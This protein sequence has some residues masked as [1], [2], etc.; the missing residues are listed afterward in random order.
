MSVL[1]EQYRS[2]ASASLDSAVSLPFA[3]YHDKEIYQ[4]ESE[5]IFR[6]EWV[7]VCAE[8][9]LPDS[10]D[11]L[12]MEL[13]GESI[14]I[15]RGKDGRLR[16]LS[17]NCRHRGTPL[18]EPG[19]GNVA[20]TIVCPYHAWSYD[21]QGALMGIPFPGAVTIKKGDHCLPEFHL[22]IYMGL[23][24]V[25]LSDAPR[26]LEHRFSGI[27]S[28]IEVFEPQRFDTA[29]PPSEEHWHANWKLTMENAM[30]SYHLFKVHRDTLEQ[31]TPTR[32]AY[33]VAGN[34]GMDAHGRRNER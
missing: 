1:L 31:V 30:E 34:A 28:L 23:V 9:S 7:F 14:A 21:T 19:F 4:L 18:L 10:G 17:N 22:G 3:V 24:F 25:N 32:S 27:E 16:A 33:Y 8:R 5:K 2:V 20:K 12:A 29:L 26:P 6:N 11:Y 15:I 13:A